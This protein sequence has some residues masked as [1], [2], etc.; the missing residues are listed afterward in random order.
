[1]KPWRFVAY[2]ALL[3]ISTEA[4]CFMLTMGMCWRTAQP[5]IIGPIAE[6]GAILMLVAAAQVAT[7]RDGED[8]RGYA[9]LAFALS[10][11]CYASAITRYPL[12]YVGI[13]RCLFLWVPFAIGAVVTSVVVGFATQRWVAPARIAA[14]LLA[15]ML[16]LFGSG[17]VLAR[18]SVG[19]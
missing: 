7:Q 6:A 11:A 2:A 14:T 18:F 12:A 8:S 13:R 19:E 16:A 5:A 15:L 10:S 1:M 4:T 9:F 3:V 17:Y